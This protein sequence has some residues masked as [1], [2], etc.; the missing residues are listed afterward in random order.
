MTQDCGVLPG[1][2][3]RRKRELDGA[4]RGLAV[5]D[6]RDLRKPP[7]RSRETIDGKTQEHRQRAVI[8]MPVRWRGCSDER[9]APRLQLRSQ[10]RYEASAAGEQQG[11][12]TLIRK[13]EKG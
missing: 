9:R 8:R 10:T 11:R 6:V 12:E 7:V 3:D 13:V 4:R 5:D 1:K 2:F